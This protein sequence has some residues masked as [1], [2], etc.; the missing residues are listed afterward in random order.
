MRKRWLTDKKIEYILRWWT[1]SAVYFFI[2]WGTG[3][4][5]QSTIIDFVF[6][7]GIALGVFEM[8]VMNPIINHMLNTGKRKPSKDKTVM[9]KVFYRLG[10]FLQIYIILIWIVIVYDVINMVGG[11]L[12][13]LEADQVFLPGEP[14]LFGVFY[15]VTYILI[16]SL[17]A[18]VR[19]SRQEEA[20]R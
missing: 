18:K 13:G 12:M 1:A 2:G 7:L 17:K 10:Y 19:R 4:G 20:T 3:F 15:I 8:F 16:E 9:Q 6:F 5:Q 14:I 11:A